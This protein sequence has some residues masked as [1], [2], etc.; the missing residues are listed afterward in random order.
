MHV[1]QHV[2]ADKSAVGDTRQQHVES[3]DDELV[4]DAK[5][6]AELQDKV[7]AAQLMAMFGVPARGATSSHAAAADS[8]Q[9]L[10][11]LAVV[12]LEVPYRHVSGVG[13]CYVGGY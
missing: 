6:F 2:G 3:C 13:L 9:E 7:A 11:S 10:D 4:L 1:W 12:R 5:A 8:I